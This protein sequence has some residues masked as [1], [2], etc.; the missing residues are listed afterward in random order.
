MT[1]PNPEFMR[2]AIRLSTENVISK[3][4]GPFG[5]IIVKD[6]KIIAR[7]TNEV[8]STNDPT[9]HAEII[10]I[11]NACKELNS[12]SLEGCEVYCSCEPC[13][14]CLSA[15]YWARAA[16]IYYGN[17]KADAAKINFDDQYIYSE[18]S[19]E[20]S[21]RS[22]PSENFLREEALEGF[23]T[24]IKFEGRIEY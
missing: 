3:K 12:F 13:P 24:W 15:I 4:G 9:A 22:I 10:A 16:K 18:I 20:H 2:E 11:R 1:E 14:M 17:T 19:K 21:E 6:G 7:G 5:C 23:Q 8:S